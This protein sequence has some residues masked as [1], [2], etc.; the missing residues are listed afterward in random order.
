MNPRDTDGELVTAFLR[1]ERAGFEALVE[2]HR[3]RLHALAFALL[4]DA[5]ESEDVVQEAMLRAFLGLAS[6]RDPARFRSW[7]SGIVA[8]VARMRLRRP[9]RESVSLDRVLEGT[10]PLPW[11]DTPSPE[12]AVELDELARTVGEALETLPEAHRGVLLRHYVEGLTCREI[13][14]RTGQSTGAVRV[15]LHRARANLRDLLPGLAPPTRRELR[16]VE[17]AIEDVY[18]RTIEQQGEPQPP[19]KQHRVVLLREKEGGRR[20]P[21]WIGAP[22]GDSLGLRLRS[23]SLPRPLTPDLTASLL[24]VTGARVERVVVSRLEEKTFYA[25]V[26]V[27]VGDQLREV[28]A[29]PSDALNLAARTNAP[30]FVDGHV[31]DQAAAAEDVSTLLSRDMGE[32]FEEGEFSAGEWRPFSRELV[33]SLWHPPSK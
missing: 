23:E 28:D 17:V 20:L 27:N 29:R 4:G 8:N 18:V 5:E 1:G 21:I 22:E 9:R 31:M 7:V 32:L 19:H 3:P 15:R 10:A 24:E 11:P 6:L 12:E 16:M 25:V 13:A 14:E 33:T 2:R 30:I 26:A